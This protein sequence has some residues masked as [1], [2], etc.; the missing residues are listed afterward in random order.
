MS[1]RSPQPAT[2]A[3]PDSQRTPHTTHHPLFHLVMAQHFYTQPAPR[4]HVFVGAVHGGHPCVFALTMDAASG[5]LRRLSDAPAALVPDEMDTSNIG[6]P[7]V[8]VDPSGGKSLYIAIRDGSR[9]ASGNYIAAFGIAVRAQPH[10][11]DTPDPRTLRRPG[12]SAR[13]RVT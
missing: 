12:P 3:T 7:W 1:S 8:T 9:D 10:P 6:G 13:A 2:P 5:S 4:H 11:P